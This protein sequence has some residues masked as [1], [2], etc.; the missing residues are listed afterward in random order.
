M[1]QHQGAIL[2]ESQ[3]EEY[4]CQYMNVGSTKPS[5]KILKF[6]KL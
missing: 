1:F 2:R 3:I 5:I 4:M 6:V